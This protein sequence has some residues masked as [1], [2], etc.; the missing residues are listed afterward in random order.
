[1]GELLHMPLLTTFNYFMA[2]NFPKA[3]SIGV[4]HTLFKR[5][6]DSEFDNYRGITVGLILAKLFVMILDER[7]SK[8]VEQ[9]GLRAKIKLGFANITT[10]L[11]NSSYYGL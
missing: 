6:D 11:T 8:R 2:E 4:V 9:Q 3:L 1:M 7:L 5:G 10:L